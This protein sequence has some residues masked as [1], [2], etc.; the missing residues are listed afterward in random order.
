MFGRSLWVHDR[1]R[2]WWT[3]ARL[4]HEA[5]LLV[6]DVALHG[7]DARGRAHTLPA[8]IPEIQ[9]VGLDARHVDRS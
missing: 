6:E 4:H 1:E 8:R 2:G 9:V 3:S 7:Q 5:T